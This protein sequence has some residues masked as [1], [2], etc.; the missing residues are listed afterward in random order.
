MPVAVR[1]FPKILL[2]LGVQKIGTSPHGSSFHFS[3]QL[4]ALSLGLSSDG[5][6]TCSA[7]EL[8]MLLAIFTFDDRG[9]DNVRVN[10][11]I[12]EK[13]RKNDLTRRLHH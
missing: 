13:R 7:Q 5:K 12:F 9:A 8:K 11:M 2:L 3:S 4:F 1:L 6:G 10:G